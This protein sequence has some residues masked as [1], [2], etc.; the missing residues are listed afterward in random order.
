[1]PI[2]R[3]LAAGALAVQIAV[4][5]AAF[6]TP[7]GAVQPASAQAGEPGSI[8]Y[9]AAEVVEAGHHVFGA[10]SGGL[11]TLVEK[12]IQ[13]YGLPNGYIIG[14]EGSGALIGGLRYGE[15]TIY[16]KLAPPSHIFWQGPSVGWDF[17]GDGNRTMM[18]V[19]NLP[20]YNSIYQ[21]FAGVNGS[22]YMV[23]GLGM[24]VLSHTGVH[25]PI[26]VVPIRTG[27]GARLGV[28]LGYLKFTSRPTWNPF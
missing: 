19:Y 3:L 27:V 9:T 4:A 17:G 11:A 15:G 26:Y 24:T 7:A 28:N 12:A 1:M 21:R 25:D 23:G 6:A 5:P 2:A 14:Q 13:R 20:S 8:N 22:A 18:L 10:A 16:T